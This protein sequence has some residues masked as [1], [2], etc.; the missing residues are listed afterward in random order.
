MS[1]CLSDQ[2]FNNVI[3]VTTDSRHPPQYKIF[4]MNGFVTMV[5]LNMYIK[6]IKG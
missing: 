6:I 5:A 2:K 1:D 4:E 3:I